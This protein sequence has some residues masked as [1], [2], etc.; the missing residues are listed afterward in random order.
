MLKK[1]HLLLCLLISGF[2]LCSCKD[3][4]PEGFTHY[5]SEIQC[6]NNPWGGVGGGLSDSLIEVFVVQFLA[7]KRIEVLDFRILDPPVNVCNS[8]DCPSGRTLEVRVAKN[9]AAHLTRLKF[10]NRKGWYAY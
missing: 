3:D 2:I 7:D 6:N 9:D 1:K 5:Y 4:Y 8:C 10:G